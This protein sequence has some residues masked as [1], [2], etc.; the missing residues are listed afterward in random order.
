MAVIN[1]WT[2]SLT[3]EM[4]KTLTT[5]TFGSTAKLREIEN[6]ILERASIPGRVKLLED[7]MRDRTIPPDSIDQFAGRLDIMEN[8][9]DR[10]AKI[11]AGLTNNSATPQTHTI[12]AQINAVK[13]T[14]EDLT[15]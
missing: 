4:I 8:Y 14:L 9:V 7:G 5:L 6:T 15:R 2:T 13:D 3:L 12:W 10:V 11:Q 1:S